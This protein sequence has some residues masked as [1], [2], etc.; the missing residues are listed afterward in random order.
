[1]VDTAPMIQYR[2]EFILAYEQRQSFLRESV[3][4][5]AVIKGNQATFLVVGSNG[6]YAVTR[7]SN[8]RIPAFAN[9]N[10][11]LTATL[12]EQHAL[13]TMNGFDI[14]RS[15]GDQRRA[16]QE[17]SMAKLNRTVDKQIIDL[18]NTGTNDTGAAVA[19][20]LDLILY[21]Q[22][23]LG[24]NFAMEDDNMEI[25]CVISDALR[26]Y[27][28]KAKEFSSADFTPNMPYAKKSM[29][30]FNWLG[31]NFIVHSNLPGKTTNAE[32]CFMYAKSSVGH[33]MD[34]SGMGVYAGYDEEQDY[35]FNR[36][37]AFMGGVLLQNSGVVVI[38]H[39]GSGFAAQ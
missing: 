28:M 30:R 27:L 24:A 4:T 20:N 33:A 35:S 7:G 15:Q 11:Q 36:A 12:T 34:T 31:I 5:E 17:N 25:T 13:H 2:Q 18:L 22:A 8:G 29:K 10:T 26:A 38:N 16:M 37:T 23:I 3:T 32:K 19:G 6:D 9:N 39:D 1:M 14:F 21:A